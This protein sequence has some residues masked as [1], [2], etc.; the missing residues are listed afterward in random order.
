V[1]ND[2]PL[3]AAPLPRAVDQNAYF[4]RIGYGGSLEPTLDTLNAIVLG[5]VQRIPFE[6]LDILLGRSISLE[7]RAIFGKLVTEERGGYCF[8]Q[9]W[10]LSQ[11]LESLGFEVTLISARSRYSL[12]TTASLPRTHVLLRVE[13]EGAS[14]LVDVGF[15]AL[16]PTAALPL[17]LNVPLVTPHEQRR[18]VTEGDWQ[19]LSLRGPEA[20]LVHQ[21]RFA[22]GWQDLFE[23]TLEPMPPADRELGNFYTSSHPRTHFKERLIVARATASGRV[24]ILDRELSFR[25]RDGSATTRELQSSGELLEVLAEHFGLHFPSGTRFDCPA[26]A[27]AP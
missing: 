17:V 9:N 2:Q 22:E 11:V 20:V 6:N 15:G 10:L 4:A 1:L 5:H 27:D 21:V 3:D 25:A 8:E 26:W 16:S 24:R 18:L 14:H 23:L 7:P 19:G 12:L 13:V